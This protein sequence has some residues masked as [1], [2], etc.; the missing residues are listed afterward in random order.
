MVGSRSYNRLNSGEDTPDRN[1][2]ITSKIDNNGS[3][4]ARDNSDDRMETVPGITH[5]NQIQKYEKPKSGGSLVDNS[6]P[7][8]DMVVYREVS[9]KA[10]ARDQKMTKVTGPVLARNLQSKGNQGSSELSDK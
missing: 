1:V 3:V 6:R 2:V 4:G 10:L 8:K 5:D 7:N 9:H